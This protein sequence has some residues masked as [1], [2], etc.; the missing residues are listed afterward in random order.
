VRDSPIFSPSLLHAA[1]TPL[2]KWVRP[3]FGIAP[4]A[5][6]FFFTMLRLFS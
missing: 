1:I 6:C 2:V 4:D 5:T 3:A